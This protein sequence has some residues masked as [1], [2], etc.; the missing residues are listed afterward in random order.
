MSLTDIGI[1][2]IDVVFAVAVM[3]A[4]SALAYLVY[5]TIRE[6][7]GQESAVRAPSGAVADLNEVRARR[8]LRSLRPSAVH[9][10]VSSS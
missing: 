7:G 5:V 8:A 4:V 6:H 9:Q 3:A 1:V 10:R 2:A